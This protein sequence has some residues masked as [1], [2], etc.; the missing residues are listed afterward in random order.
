MP[1]LFLID[2][3]YR[4]DRNDNERAERRDFSYIMGM[5]SHENPRSQ[6]RSF[7]IDLSTRTSFFF[8]SRFSL[9]LFSP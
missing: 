4:R 9:F 2:A 8:I 7:H 1:V 5:K 3:R 6:Q